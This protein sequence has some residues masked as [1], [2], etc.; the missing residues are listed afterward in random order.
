MHLSEDGALPGTSGHSLRSRLS[1]LGQGYQ[2]FCS[3]QSL[4]MLVL[5]TVLPVMISTNIRI[6]LS[7]TYKQINTVIRRYVRHTIHLSNCL[8]VSGVCMYVCVCR[9]L[10]KTDA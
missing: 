7:C 6:I 3:E 1:V 4:V 2:S 8:Y 9:Y 5:Y 10:E